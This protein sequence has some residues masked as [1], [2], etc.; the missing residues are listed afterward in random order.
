L[1]A[2]GKKTT[3]HVE[4]GANTQI[5]RQEIPGERR[6]WPESIKRR[7]AELNELGLSYTQIAE[8]ALRH[9]VMGRKN[10]AGSKSIDGADVA[11]VLYTVIESAKRAGLQPRDY[12][13]Y[14]VTERW[15]KRIPLSPPRLARLQNDQYKNHD[16]PKKDAWRI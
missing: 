9:I 16:A 3:R 7:V 6:A 13:K 4:V 14:V 10:F 15:Y 8:R 2:P 1:F 5:R 12:L 11:A